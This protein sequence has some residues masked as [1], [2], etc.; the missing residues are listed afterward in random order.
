MHIAGFWQE[1]IHPVGPHCYLEFK[2]Y[3]VELSFKAAT[4]DTAC[5]YLHDGMALQGLGVAHARSKGDARYAVG[6]VCHVVF[7]IA[8]IEPMKRRQDIVVDDGRLVDLWGEVILEIGKDGVAATY[9]AHLGDVD[10]FVLALFMEGLAVEL[11]AEK[12]PVVAFGN[13]VEPWYAKHQRVALVGG[14]QILE[15]GERG[16]AFDAI[17]YRQAVVIH[18]ADDKKVLLVVATCHDYTRHDEH[19]RDEDKA[20]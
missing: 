17:A 13:V 11:L 12:C 7:V 5:G 19:E 2:S 9:G 15:I 6:K 4:V 3:Q 10:R 1:R 20:I 16:G 14:N 8:A 18:A